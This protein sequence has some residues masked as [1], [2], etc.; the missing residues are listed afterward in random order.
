VSKVQRSV[1]LS[2]RDPIIEI[3]RPRPATVSPFS[4]ARP[5]SVATMDNPNNVKAS[6]SGDPIASSTGRKI[7]M[8]SASTMAPIR[9]PA[10]EAANPAPNARPASPL[11]A[12]AWP[13]IT[14]A[15]APT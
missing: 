12:I 2:E 6:S 1:P 14:V 13:S 9:P 5:D 10:S 7:G 4:G 3:I 15:A 8:L 11:R